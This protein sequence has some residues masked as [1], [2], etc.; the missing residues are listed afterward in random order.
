MFSSELGIYTILLIFETFSIKIEILFIFSFDTTSTLLQTTCYELMKNPDIQLELYNEID[1]VA[2]TLEGKSISFE[3][4]HKMTFLDMVVSEGLRKWPPI[5][6]T[7]RICTKD[8]DV[9][10]GNGKTITIKKDQQ[11]LFPYYHIQNDPA[12]FPNPEKFDPHRFGNENKGSIVQGTYL[13]FGL[14]RRNCIGSRFALMEAKL[15]LFN[16]VH[17]FSIQKGLKTPG[18]VKHME[19]FSPSIKETVYLKF[20]PRK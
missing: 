7:N 2:S 9:V 16:L 1:S 14:G 15:L 4:L 10:L 18:T 13:P 6:Q 8:Y 17:K 12:Y 5:I 3:E 11:I 19:G 20:V